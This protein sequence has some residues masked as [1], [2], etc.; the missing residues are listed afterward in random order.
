[1]LRTV[2]RLYQRRL[3]VRRVR[4]RRVP[5]TS[6]TDDHEYDPDRDVTYDEDLLDQDRDRDRGIL[7]TFILISIVYLILHHCI[8]SV[9]FY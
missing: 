5:N 7:S 3:A 1:M 2:N 8:I 6:Y 4:R 9:I